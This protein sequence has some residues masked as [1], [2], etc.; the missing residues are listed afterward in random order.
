[1]TTPKSNLPNQITKEITKMSIAN[2][3]GKKMS[4]TVKF[5]GEDIKISKL[6]VAEVLKIQE[7]AKDL[8][9]DDSKGFEVLKTVIQSSV[10]GGT[11]LQD[12]DFENFPMDELSK[13]SNEIMKYSG[14]GGEE[15]KGK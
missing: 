11:E 13:L 12:G 1:M 14:I 2:L 7:A 8:D 15:Q 10:E 6:S 3:I 5:M 9:T 4:K